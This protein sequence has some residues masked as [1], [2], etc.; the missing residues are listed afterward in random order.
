[1][2]GCKERRERAAWR[3]AFRAVRVFRRYDKVVDIAAI[4]KLRGAGDVLLHD[5]LHGVAV[6]INHLH[7]DFM[8][9]RKRIEKVL[10][11]FYSSKKESE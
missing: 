4:L 5:V 3:A 9:S 10:R 6:Q 7:I 2:F 8:W 11:R 1:M